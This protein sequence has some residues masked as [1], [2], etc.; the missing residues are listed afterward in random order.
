[1]STNCATNC[2]VLNTGNDILIL[3]EVHHALKLLAEKEQSTT[4]DLRSIP[5]APGEEDKI[6]DILGTGE[7]KVTLDSMGISEI[8]ETGISGVWLITH[9][10]LAQEVTGKFLEITRVPD[11]ILTH[12]ED[13]K[14][15]LS[16]LK[17][18]LKY[19][20]EAL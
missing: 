19:E 13:L 15:G 16:R 1:M 10:N 7:I 18:L 12:P 9:Y 8:I 3:N 20:F 14:N 17:Q 5:M 2:D 11:L 4:I 6:N